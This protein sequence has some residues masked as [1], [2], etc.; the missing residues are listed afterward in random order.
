MT[1][2]CWSITSILRFSQRKVLKTRNIQWA[3]ASAR[4]KVLSWCQRSEQTIERQQE[5]KGPPVT[6]PQGCKKKKNW[7]ILIRCTDLLL[8][9]E[10]VCTGQS[11][12]RRRTHTTTHKFKIRASIVFKDVL[13]QGR[14][15]LLSCFIHELINIARNRPPLTCGTLRQPACASPGA[16][17][18]WAR[19]LSGGSREAIHPTRRPAVLSWNNMR[20]FCHHKRPFFFPGAPSTSY[21][22]SKRNDL[23][24]I[25]VFILGKKRKRKKESQLG[26]A[27][28]AV[29]LPRQLRQE[30]YS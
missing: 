15:W 7:P 25:I 3:P 9:C 14:G 20:T 4:R 24:S 23:P 26:S 29:R 18:R 5:V 30:T 27:H 2:N 13:L 11:S 16:A 21:F 6:V 28:W 8:G 17:R 22:I 12:W 19:R 10:G 1:E